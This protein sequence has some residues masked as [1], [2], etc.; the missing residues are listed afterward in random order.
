VDQNRTG[1]CL[2]LQ[3]GNKYYDYLCDCHYL[4]EI[5]LCGVSYEQCALNDQQS[6][7]DVTICAKMLSHT[8]KT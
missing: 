4:N 8:F 1:Y 2:F 3:D 7:N 5:L 6:T